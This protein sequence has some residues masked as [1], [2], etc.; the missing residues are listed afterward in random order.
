MEPMMV[1]IPVLVFFATLLSVA[2][3][4]GYL[5]YRSERQEIINRLQGTERKTESENNAESGDSPL[6]KIVLSIVSTFSGLT[7]PKKKEELTQT[8]QKFLRAGYRNPKA[9]LLFYGAKAFLPVAILALSVIAYFFIDHT[10][11]VFKVVIFSL[12]LAL[13]GYYLPDLW[14]RLRLAR[15]KDAIFKGFPDALDMLVVCVEAGMGMDA[16]ISRIA[17]EMA[18]S[19]K[20]LSDELRQVNLE[21]RAGKSR[22]EAL[23]NLAFRADLEDVESLVSL[24]IQTDKFGTNIAQALRV[25]SDSMRTK[26]FQKAEEIAGK[27]TVKLIFPLIL[28]IFPS[29]FVAIMGPA[30]IRVYRTFLG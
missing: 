27:L 23:R 1:L 3:I 24:L 20:I 29:L 10:M 12:I 28:F 15:R 13:A 21:V 19:N 17:E 25:Y 2:G 14:L 6:K 4:A 22:Q 11:P 30:M 16:A 18:L 8:R 5:K 26:R 9:S 7:Q